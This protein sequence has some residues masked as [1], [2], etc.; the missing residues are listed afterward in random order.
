MSDIQSKSSASSVSTRKSVEHLQNIDLI[1]KTSHQIV[2]A[3][4]PSNRQVLQLFF[5]NMRFVNRSKLIDTKYLAKLTIDAAKIF[6]QQARIPI[7]GDHK[8]KEQLLKLYADWNTIRKTTPDKRSKNQRE[9]AESFVD[10]LDDLFDIAI[11]NAL[12]EMKIP[13][14]K[15]FLEMQ[16]QKGRPGSMSGVDMTLYGQEKRAQERKEKE[17]AR[18]KK[19]DEQM[20]QQKGN[21]AY[22]VYLNN[23]F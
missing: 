6:W 22:C 4:L 20:A 14:D 1:G 8:C 9:F 12:N 2:G 3:K 19:H 13:E 18:K 11:A 7:R 15:K 10:S 23:I 21:S 17:D 16:R 5:Y